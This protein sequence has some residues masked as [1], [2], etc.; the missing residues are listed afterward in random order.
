M[1]QTQHKWPS[2][3][4]IISQQLIIYWW[5]KEYPSSLVPEK[6]NIQ[7]KHIM[8]W[9]KPNITQSQFRNQKET[10]W[11]NQVN[12][13]KHDEISEKE[14]LSNENVEEVPWV[15]DIVWYNSIPV[16]D[17]DNNNNRVGS[18]E[19]MNWEKR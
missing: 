17:D 7:H 6:R 11:S 14:K 19:G 1:Y 16:D 8:R 18:L 10:N 5:E 9:I 15:P 2:K 4:L 13:F 12:A 3:A